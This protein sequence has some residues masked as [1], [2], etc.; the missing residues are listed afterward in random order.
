MWVFIIVAACVIIDQLSKL[1]VSS[2]MQLHDSF[3]LIP[4]L[5]NIRYIQNKGAAFG[6]LQNHR[7]VFLIISTIAIGAMIY[8]LVRIMRLPKY[9]LMKTTFAMTIGGGIGN[10]IDRLR[11]GYVTDFLEFDFVEFAI[12]NFADS[13]VCV[14]SVLFCICLLVGKNDAVF[15]AMIPSKMKKSIAENLNNDDAD[16]ENSAEPNQDGKAE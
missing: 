15:N 14:G 1:I 5:I 4:H 7:W 12:F 3:N 6:M 11:L 16:N 2:Q 8:L 9:Y 13:F 10:M